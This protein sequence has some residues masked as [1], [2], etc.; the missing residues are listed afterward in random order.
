MV[1]QVLKW[2]GFGSEDLQTSNYLRPT[3]SPPSRVLPSHRFL[4]LQNFPNTDKTRAAWEF[5]IEILK[6]LELRIRCMELWM[7]GNK[8]RLKGKGFIWV[9]VRASSL[10]SWGETRSAGK[11]KEALLSSHKAPVL[12]PPLWLIFLP[13]RWSRLKRW[14]WHN[15]Y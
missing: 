7:R 14:K 6:T 3:T 11:W 15:P 13:T 5:H 10:R 8:R 12:L 2:D 4:E 9:Q 1:Y